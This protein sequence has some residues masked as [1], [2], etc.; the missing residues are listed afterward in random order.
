MAV[1]IPKYDVKLLIEAFREHEPTYFPGV[2]TLFISLLNHPEAAS[3]GLDKVRGFNSG[4]APL[5]VEII[6]RFEQL[7]GAML[8]EGY[9]MTELS[10]TASST[11]LLAKR[12]PGS[13]GLPTVGTSF[14]IVD[15][16]TGTTEVEVGGE[17][18]LCV[19]GPQVMKGYWNKPEE[20]ANALRD[21]WM[22]TGDIARM[23]ADGFFYI[24]QRKKDM[25]IVSGFK[26]F[27]GEVEEVLFTHPAVVEAAVI[28]VPHEYRGEAVKAFVVTRREVSAEDV[29]EY[30]KERLAKYKVP[31]QVEFI[32]ALPKTGVGKVLRR[33]LR[34]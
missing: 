2:P 34:K 17:G 1:L 21:G 4:S 32:E 33:E 23:D 15:L 9:G 16:D 25:I 7:S 8:R 31:S 11:P 22:H 26:V 3:C 19:K 29:I 20:T 24:V 13:I 10:C 6:E 27:P 14:K 18:E 5:P 28:G 12:K 30:C